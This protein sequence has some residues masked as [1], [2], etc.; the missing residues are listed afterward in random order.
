MKNDYYHHDIL[1]CFFLFS[2]LLEDVSNTVR[3]FMREFRGVLSSLLEPTSMSSILTVEAVWESIQIEV[4]SYALR[5]LED[6]GSNLKQTRV[7]AKHS[8]SRSGG[9]ADVVPLD[10]VWDYIYRR[11][12]TP[13]RTS[14]L[15]IPTGKIQFSFFDA[16]KAQDRGDDKSERLDSMYDMSNMSTSLTLQRNSVFRGSLLF[17]LRNGM[18]SSSQFLSCLMQRSSWMSR[19]QSSST[20]SFSSSAL[21]SPLL[22]EKSSPYNMLYFHRPLVSFA[23]CCR[24]LV[25]DSPSDGFSRSP[26]K[27]DRGMSSNARSVL[28]DFVA[29]FSV[30]TFLPCLSEEFK[31]CC[32]ILLSDPLSFKPRETQ[33]HIFDPQDSER[34]L[35]A[36]RLFPPLFDSS[37]IFSH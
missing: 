28:F 36:V 23:R 14:S 11:S 33:G 21:L 17:Y 18:I 27:F 37:H 8:F 19:K 13:Q 16:H 25:G 31:E 32:T 15:L 10:G 26:Q 5:F 24:S 4:Q 35:L 29:S 6:F 12:S 9:V 34:P 7:D 1:R 2:A 30:N 3:P 20:P 22:E